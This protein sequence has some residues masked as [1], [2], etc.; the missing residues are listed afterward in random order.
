MNNSTYFIRLLSRVNKMIHV[1]LPECLACSQQCSM[2][3]GYFRKR[4]SAVIPPRARYSSNRVEGKGKEG[5]NY[6]REIH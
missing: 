5:W 6:M 1:V 2:N 3:A 4:T